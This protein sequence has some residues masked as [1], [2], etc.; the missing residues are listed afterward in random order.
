MAFEN[1]NLINPVSDKIR[2]KQKEKEDLFE[3][4]MRDLFTEIFD[5]E[6]PENRFA[7]F[8]K[9]LAGFLN[10][11]INLGLSQAEIDS[12]T[13]N[14]RVCSLIKEKE[15]FIKQGLNYLQPLVDWKKNNAA[16]FETIMRENFVSS[17]GFIKLNESLSYGKDKDDIHIHVAPSETLSVGEKFSLLKDGLRRL[18]EIVKNDGEIKT[19]S[20]TS[21][22]V[23]TKQGKGIM[24]KLGFEVTGEISKELKE[25]FFR[26]ETRP[27]FGAYINREDFLKPDRYK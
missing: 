13:N 21:W 4:K 2:D 8:E 20:A 15:G 25:K 12:V 18:Q 23:A 6:E 22:I 5:I 11:S 24:E 17:S 26:L 9:R 19:V 16:P 14:L 3:K 7:E 27:V 10:I 1:K